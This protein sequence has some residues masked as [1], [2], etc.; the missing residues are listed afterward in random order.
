[1]IMMR[2]RDNE[3]DSGSN[4]DEDDDED[5]AERQGLDDCDDGDNNSD[6]A[7]YCSGSGGGDCGG[8]GRLSNR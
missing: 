8:T 7:E 3:E 4:C 5:G 6:V 2:E 1:M